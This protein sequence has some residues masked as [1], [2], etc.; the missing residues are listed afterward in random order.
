VVDGAVALIP[1]L[2]YEPS[3]SGGERKAPI[4]ASDLRRE[5]IE[6]DER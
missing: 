2:R 3:V 4:D 5:T 1:A 6:W